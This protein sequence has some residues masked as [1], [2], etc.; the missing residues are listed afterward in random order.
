MKMLLTMIS[1]C[2]CLGAVSKEGDTDFN[3]GSETP[4]VVIEVNDKCNGE[5]KTWT[6]NKLLPEM[7]R[8]YPIICD[9]LQQEGFEPAKKITLN[10]VP[11]GKPPAWA[12][13]SSVTLNMKWARNELNREAVGAVIHELAHV[14]QYYNWGKNTS[15]GWICEGIADY[16]RWMCYESEKNR[17]AIIWDA[18][19][20]SYNDSYRTT[21]AFLYWCE[22]N[23]KSGI[24][25]RL[26]AVCRK[27]SYT[28]KFWVNETGETVVELDKEWKKFNKTL[29][30]DGTT[31]VKVGSYNVRLSSGDRNTPN[32]WIE[33]REDLIAHIKELDL[34]VFGMQEVR[35]D[36]AEYFRKQLDD[37][38]FVGE[39]RGS[40][41]KSDEA[42]PVFYRK[43]RFEAKKAGTFWLSETP[44]K[45]GSRGW[46]A[47]C[48]RVCSYVILKDKRTGKTFCFANTHT[49]HASALAREKGML[50]VLQRMKSFGEGA[51]IVFVGDHNCYEH[52]APAKAVSKILRDTL[53]V[54]ETPPKGSWRTFNGWTWADAEL[55]ATDAL[56]K[57]VGSRDNTN[58][59]IKRI[60]YIYVSPD[61][62]VFNYKSHCDSRPGQNLYYSD[63]FPVTATVLFPSK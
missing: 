22:K 55:T 4:S 47:M 37:W 43:S 11:D 19:N 59:N 7:K 21:A 2:M 40:D 35:P 46:K 28:E 60:D 14:V 13:G 41:R 5:F 6:E 33:R 27:N 54:T 9:L 51:P 63:H 18:R 53:Y 42:S 20:G 26:N 31:C 57:P 50:L 58:A 62:R 34:D 39:H 45:P 3:N 36:A 12:S 44:D 30:K 10:L 32:A 49:D 48:P 1:A 38:V 56:K 8:F 24:V 25:K 23:V 17:K 16:I 61:V 15:P 29:T 52:E